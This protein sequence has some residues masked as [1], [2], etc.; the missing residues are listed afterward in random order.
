MEHIPL[1]LQKRPCLN[2]YI[3]VLN[4]EF[5]FTNL[6]ETLISLCLEF[7]FIKFALCVSVD[8]EEMPGTGIH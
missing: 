7:Y 3:R 6:I 4:I 2:I 8:R 5:N 1:L